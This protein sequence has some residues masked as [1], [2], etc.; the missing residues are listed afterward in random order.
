MYLSRSTRLPASLVLG[1]TDRGS[2]YPQSTI[3]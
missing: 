3:G 1:N 2:R